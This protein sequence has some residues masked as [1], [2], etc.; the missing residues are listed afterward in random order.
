MSTM[1]YISWV[2]YI[3]AVKVHKTLTELRIEVAG[4]AIIFNLFWGIDLHRLLPK[5]SVD[6]ET[7]DVGES[8][9][10]ILGPVS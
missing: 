7:T 2:V 10:S 3:L 4:E 8:I 6:R 1:K 5:H 9:I